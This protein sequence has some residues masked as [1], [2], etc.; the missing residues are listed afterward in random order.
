MSFSP[1]IPQNKE[2]AKRLFSAWLKGMLARHKIK[3]ILLGQQSG[4]TQN[5][6]YR[7]T[8][9]RSLPSILGLYAIVSALSELTGIDQGK[10][11]KDIYNALESKS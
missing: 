3:A 9:G 11:H 6:I 5:D 1:P 8:S 7:W 4:F 10:L 2:R